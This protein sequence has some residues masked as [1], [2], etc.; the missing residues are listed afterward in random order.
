MA[1]ALFSNTIDEVISLSEYISLYD[2]GVAKT[3][4]S[5]IDTSRL[6]SL[7][8]SMFKDYSE[9]TYASFPN[10]INMGYDVF[11]NCKKL[12]E[13][14][15]PIFSS[16]ILPS[17][18]ANCSMLY[19]FDCNNYVNIENAAY[20]FY[21]CRA[22]QSIKVTV[23]NYIIPTSV[24]YSCGNLKTVDFKY[25]G[26]YNSQANRFVDAYAF[27]N[28]SNLQSINIS[29][30]NKISDYAFYNC[31]T[32]YNLQANELITVGSSAF[33]NCTNLYEIYGYSLQEIDNDAFNG[34]YHLTNINVS[35]VTNISDRAFYY[36]SGLSSNTFSFPELI[37][38]GS[39]AF[40]QA[41]RFG[42]VKKITAN[43]LLSL[44]QFAFEYYR[45]SSA[46]NWINGG[47][48]SA[49]SVYMSVEFNSLENIPSYGLRVIVD[50][51]YLPNCKR[52]EHHALAVESY[53]SSSS[54]STWYLKVGGPKEI[55]LPECTFFGMDNINGQYIYSISM[56][57]VSSFWF[58]NMFIKRYSTTSYSPNY[59]VI[60]VQSDYYAYNLETLYMPRVSLMTL[61]NIG[62]SVSKYCSKLT[63]LGI[64]ATSFYDSYITDYLPNLQNLIINCRST[65][66]NINS[67]TFC[68]SSLD[69]S[70]LNIKLVR[71]TVVTGNQALSIAKNTNYSCS[72]LTNIDITD[73]TML[74]SS[75]YIPDNIQS[76]NVGNIVDF[77]DTNL[78][79]SAFSENSYITDFR[80][81]SF[82]ELYCASST[83]SRGIGFYGFTNL[84]QVRFPLLS[85]TKFAAYNF[86]FSN[87]PNINELYLPNFEKSLKI[88][89]YEGNN[90]SYLN[91]NKCNKLSMYF[92]TETHFDY[93]SMPAIISYSHNAS[94]EYGY[95]YISTTSSSLFTVSSLYLNNCERIYMAFST[96][97]YT[98][99]TVQDLYLP[100]LSYFNM[101]GGPYANYEYSASSRA[102]FYNN[103]KNLYMS[104]CTYINI[105]YSN[106]I[107]YLSY[108]ASNISYFSV[109]A[110][111]SSIKNIQMTLHN[112]TTQSAF[113]LHKVS[114]DLSGLTINALYS[115]EFPIPYTDY[116]VHI[117]TIDVK[118]SSVLTIIA[119]RTL[120]RYYDT[121]T[122]EQLVIHDN[123]IFHDTMLYEADTINTVSNSSVHIAVNNL[124]RLKATNGITISQPLYTPTLVIDHPG[125]SVLCS[126]PSNYI[127]VY[128]DSEAYPV[129]VVPSAAYNAYLSAWS[130][131]HI[132]IVSS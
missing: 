92:D 111:L 22:L 59:R 109:F 50:K 4:A 88:A 51:L 124:L 130:E 37:S 32:L 10:V 120:S 35:K 114:G 62:S 75:V 7:S 15:L 76:F 69:I 11:M 12:S 99:G 53:Y 122:G 9:L 29:R 103:F 41:V 97:W 87:C 132:S 128:G 74:A 85:G 1:E 110:P 56:P 112:S 125:S 98:L 117:S 131:Y 18:F 106:S 40:H 94:S 96:N 107:D 102:G 126:L 23:A 38:I 127:S 45:L 49:N 60:S 43:K 89:C 129:V 116:N 34:C 65:Y 27:Y 64:S 79:L 115:L 72:Y 84:S 78:R 55:N 86:V 48:Y 39:G 95:I 71:D 108:D 14:H 105:K 57:K 121:V 91:L 24:F 17:A 81:T 73:F 119:G 36:C 123:T 46:I 70:S 68:F 20:G 28:C 61:L 104:K 25:S 63:T 54:N 90:L 101:V 93:I 33:Y 80:F 58:S 2:A 8:A 21:S 13:I 5:Y 66:G 44:S 83:S 47:D 3:T 30:F 118:C 82:E 42:I 77:T 67:I 100:N 19:N 6:T 31:R 16:H 52:V 113:Y 26:I